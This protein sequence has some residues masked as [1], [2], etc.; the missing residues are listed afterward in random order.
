[1]NLM[2]NKINTCFNNL[3]NVFYN[4][5]SLNKLPFKG[6]LTYF[7]LLLVGIISSIIIRYSYINGLILP[8]PEY[9][10]NS[11]MAFS[12]LYSLFLF[13][14]YIFITANAFKLIDFFSLERKRNAKQINNTNIIFIGYYLYYL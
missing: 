11:I 4:I 3:I 5:I 6:S 1:M 9:I 12:I 10:N 14:N 13:F 7:L 8:F 2:I